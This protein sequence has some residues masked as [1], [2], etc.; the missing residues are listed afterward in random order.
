MPTARLHDLGTVIFDTKERVLCLGNYM[1]AHTAG[2]DI[3]LKG[4]LDYIGR[5][6]IYPDDFIVSNDPFIVKYGHS[7]DWSFLRPV[8]YEGDLL[9]YH[10]MR[11]HQY[12]GGGA[13]QGCYFVRPYDCYSEGLI[14]LSRQKKFL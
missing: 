4:M 14:A 12:D 5:D 6:N 7:P 8:F 10:Y 2:S 11:T 9:F 1:P 13:Y 3:C